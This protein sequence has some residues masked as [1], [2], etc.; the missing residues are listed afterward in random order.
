[1]VVYAE[2][3][4]MIYDVQSLK[5]KRSI[6]KRITKRV[7]NEFNFSIAEIE[8]E[9]LWQRTKLGIATVSNEYVHAEKVIQQVIRFIDQN[10]EVERTIT[11]IYPL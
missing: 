7:Q 11:N 10:P 1:M 8:F 3:E 4:Y 6:V 5:E 2:V 9:D